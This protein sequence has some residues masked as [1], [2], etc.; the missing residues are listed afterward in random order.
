MLRITAEETPEGTAIK[1]EG[2]LAGALVNELAET[3]NGL[4]TNAQ[5]KPVLVDLC[6]VTFIDADGKRL[7]RRLYSEGATLRCC[8]PDITATVETIERERRF[9]NRRPESTPS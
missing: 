6:G 5:S 4:S 9:K 3:W 7:L 2:R 8:G 1:L